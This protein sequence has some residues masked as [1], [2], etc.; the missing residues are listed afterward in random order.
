MHWGFS[1]TYIHQPRPLGLSSSPRKTHGSVI[2]Q[3]ERKYFIYYCTPYEVDRTVK[4]VKDWQP[5]QGDKCRTF[6]S[7]FIENHSGLRGF[8]ASKIATAYLL[9]ALETQFCVAREAVSVEISKV[10]AS[11]QEGGALGSPAFFYRSIG[12]HCEPC[13]IP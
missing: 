2:V 13:R 8:A 9:K 5:H 1:R 11:I 4:C 12:V 6:H 3:T 10:E 7:I